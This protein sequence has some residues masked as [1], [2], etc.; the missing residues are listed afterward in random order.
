MFDS[1]YHRILKEGLYNAQVFIH[2][3]NYNGWNNWLW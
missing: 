3:F 2:I 1:S